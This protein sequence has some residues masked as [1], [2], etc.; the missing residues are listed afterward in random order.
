MANYNNWSDDYWPLVFQ[1]Y[2]LKPK[3][4]KSE[5]SKPVVDLAIE[6]HLNPKVL[7]EKMELADRHDS[8]SL[9]RLWNLYADNTRRLNRDAKTVKQMAGFGNAGLFYDGVTADDDP[10]RD[11]MPI[12]GD[13][14]VSTA[15]LTMVLRLYFSL[16]PVTMVTDTPEVQE[17]ARLTGLPTEHLVELLQLFQTFDPIL[18]RKPATPSPVADEAQRLWNRFYNDTNLLDTAAARF[19]EYFD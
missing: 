4:V 18:R 17:T 5:W 15:V 8:P 14:H 12:G 2:M 3:G 11:Y 9:R 6:L 7:H 1:A 16:T 19:E 10:C 13:T